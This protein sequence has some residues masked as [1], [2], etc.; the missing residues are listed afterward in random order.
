MPLGSLDPKEKKVPQASLDNQVFL[1]QLALQ[2]IQVFMVLR[3]KRE[4]RV[5][6]VYLPFQVQM[7]P[8][9]Q[10]G[11]RGFQEYQEKMV[12]MGFQGP[13][14]LLAHVAQQVYKDLRATR[15]FQAYLAHLASQQRAWLV[16]RVYLECQALEVKMV[17]QVQKA[18]L[19][20]QVHQDQWFM[21][22]IRAPQSSHVSFC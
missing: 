17:Y 14:D 4:S 12:R 2:E 9:D 19:V 6:L 10:K 21:S 20:Q 1:G 3:V 5:V 7:A 18:H 16:L 8:Q 15:V 13:W 22:M 11:T